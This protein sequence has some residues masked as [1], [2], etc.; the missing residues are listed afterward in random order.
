MVM[1]VIFEGIVKSIYEHV[2]PNPLSL[3]RVQRLVAHI[4]MSTAGW[5]H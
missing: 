3:R 1:W 4:I 5:L 2:P